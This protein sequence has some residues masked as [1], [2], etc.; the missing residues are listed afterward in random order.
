MAPPDLAMGRNETLSQTLYDALEELLED[1]FNI[2]KRKLQDIDHDGKGEIPKVQLDSADRSDVIHLMC[3][4]YGEANA[5][6]VC[7]CVLEHIGKEDIAANL[8]EA[9]RKGAFSILLLAHVLFLGSRL[10]YR[11]YIKGKFQSIKVHPSLGENLLRS[12]QYSKLTFD[13]ESPRKQEEEHEIMALGWVYFRDTYMDYCSLQTEYTTEKLFN[14]DRNGLVP[15]IVVLQGAAGTGKTTTNKKKKRKI[16]FDW[17]CGRLYQAMFDFVFYINC[18]EM[19]LCNEDSSIAE[20]ILKRWPRQDEIKK[21]LENPKKLL[22]VIDGFDELRCSLQPDPFCTDPWQ[23]GP[24]EVLLGS[25]LKKKLLP[26]S[27]LIITTRPTA[28]GYLHECSEELRRHFKILGFSKEDREKYFHKF[29]ENK[30]RATQAF[31]LVKQNETLFTMCSVPLV[32]CIICMVLVQQMENSEDL[33]QTSNTLTAVYMLYLSSLLKLHHNS[34]SK[35]HIRK[36]LKSL[37]SLAADGIWKRKIL[38]WEEEIKELGLDQE[39]SLPL[40]LSKSIF[41]RN[42]ECERA[43]SFIHLSFQEFFAALSYLLEEGEGLSSENPNRDVVRLLESYAVSRP[44]LEVTVRFLFGLVN[45]G[46]GMKDMKEQFGWKFL[47]KIKEVLLE[48]VKNTTETKMDVHERH[49]HRWLECLY[50]NQEENFVESAL[51]HVTE[52][53]VHGRYLTKTRVTAQAYSLLLFCFIVYAESF[54]IYRFSPFHP[55]VLHRVKF[56]S[57]Q[58]VPCGFLASLLSVNSTLLELELGRSKVRDSGLKLL[59]EGLKHPN[60]QIQKVMLYSCGLTGACC[61]DLSSVLCTKQTLTDLDLSDNALGNFGIRQLSEGLKHPNCRLQKLVLSNCSF[62]GTACWGF[63]KVLC[64]SQTLRELD[65]RFNKVWNIGM[66][67]L[68]MGLKDPACKL[69]NLHITSCGDLSSAL[70]TNQMLKQVDLRDN[71]LGDSEVRLLCEGL[72]HPNCKLEVLSLF[73]C[74]LTADCCKALSSALITNQTLRKL[75]LTWNALGDSGVKLL[76]EGLKHPDCKLQSL[77]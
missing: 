15:Q 71:K 41:R 26:E 34:P 42:I 13:I 27:Y 24:V 2:F 60:C 48:W 37:C 75:D 7:I 30:D 8:N 43:Y 51:D 4:F 22:F 45:E 53:T 25:L 66:M 1:Q 16:M 17:A 23:K 56:F 3:D 69:E 32:C 36:N 9:T 44:D 18:G 73:A 76:C 68:C 40:F 11:D 35:E 20:I 65:L 70:A 64:T 63:A 58:L 12:C 5:V 52:V 33:W 61:E 46:K 28:L 55:I 49:K 29:F 59:A 47:P 14:P 67:L 21:M 54:S 72:N 39:D 74:C 50:E 19:N 57:E 6:K 38:F 62:S 77:R 10:T 31:S